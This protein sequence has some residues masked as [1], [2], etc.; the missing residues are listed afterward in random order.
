MNLTSR[1]MELFRLLVRYEKRYENDNPEVGMGPSLETLARRVAAKLSFPI[2]DEDIQ[3]CIK[4]NL[5]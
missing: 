1:E 3:L 2:N 5:L 4:S